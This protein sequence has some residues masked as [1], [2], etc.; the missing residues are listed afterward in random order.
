MTLN[1]LIAEV[2][3]QH[4]SKALAGYLSKNLPI[5]DHAT[6]TI[7]MEHCEKRRLCVD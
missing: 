4:F 5:V 1:E 6:A 2:I 7:I 3:P